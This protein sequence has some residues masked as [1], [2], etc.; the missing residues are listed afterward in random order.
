M[1]PYVSIIVPVYNTKQYLS[2]CLNSILKQS[3]ADFE[4]ILVD[5]GSSDGSGAICDDYAKKDL[6]I[7]VFHT[8]NK[9]VS[10][11]RNLGLD[12]A[13]G[14]F[15]M[16]VDSDDELSDGA[17]ESMVSGVS[18]FSVGGML[19]IINGHE[20]EFRYSSD[21]YYQIDRKEHFLDDAFSCPVLLEG[22]AAKLY[23]TDTIRQNGLRFNENL[24]YGE[25]KVFVFSYLLYA[26]S[27]RTLNNIVYIQK[28]RE[29]SLS[30]DISSQAHLKPLIAFLTCYVDVV[31]NFEKVFSCRSVRDLFPMDVIRR[32]V[33]RYLTII[34]NTKPK[35]LSRQDLRFISSLLKDERVMIC[36]MD[37]TYLKSCVWIG[38]NL[39]AFFLYG[40][41]CLLN[42]MR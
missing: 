23:K 25:D 35:H 14:L 33:F 10:S 15:V 16:F 19:R 18:D 39:P 34:R 2:A 9:G 12:Q 28:R 20:Q 17:L 37:R 13:Q 36:R 4:L 38:K 6:R 27:F 41:L 7:S 21:S 5:D 3:F 26:D 24:R 29:R 1:S 31:S 42:V 22:P 32:Y 8:V 30:S 40:F 11:A